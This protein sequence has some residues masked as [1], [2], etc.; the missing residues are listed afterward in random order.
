MSQFKFFGRSG[1]YWMFWTG[2]IYLAIGLPVAVYYKDIRPELVQL[3]W[4]LALSMPF[5]FPPFGRWL[6]MSINWDKNMF[7]FFR[8][9][10]A[11]DYLEE[12]SN[13][14]NL[15]PPKAVPYVEPPKAPE[16]PAMTYYR[17]GITDNSRVSLQMGHSEITMNAAGINNMIKQLECF[18]DQIAEYEDTG[19]EE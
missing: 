13:V 15:P 19:E 5:I 7:D 11:K 14:Y 3:V 18:R 9:R 8:R 17:L 12:A 16:K 6:N 10:T 2:A 4:L 1:G